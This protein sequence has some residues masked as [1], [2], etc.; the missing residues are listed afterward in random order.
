[1]TSSNPL[2]TSQLVRNHLF[3][4]NDLLDLVDDRVYTS[5][6]FEFDDGTIEMPMV[7]IELVGGSAN[8]ASENQKVNL[9]MYAYSRLSA[10]QALE[11]YQAM[12]LQL[13][14]SD[15]KNDAIGMSG[16]AIEIE[17]P[18]MGYMDSQR[19]Y[20]YRGRFSLFTVG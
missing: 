14:A 3:K 16:T 15:L 1:M 17:R 4:S 10:G 8:Y 6:F 18:I 2:K 7:I 13:H 20:F 9:H 11:V 12:Y 19:A 5:H